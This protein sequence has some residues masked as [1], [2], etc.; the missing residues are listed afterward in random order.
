MMGP[1]LE[2]NFFFACSK[3]LLSGIKASS[4]TY[5]PGSKSLSSN[6]VLLPA[7]S[8]VV[9]FLIK[10]NFIWSKELIMPLTIWNCV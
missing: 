3:Y 10:Q 7:N 5:I 2:I 8:I 6:A 4:N 9:R 1:A